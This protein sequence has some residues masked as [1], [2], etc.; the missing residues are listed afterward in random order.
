MSEIAYNTFMKRDTFLLSSLS[1]HAYGIIAD[2]TF[3]AEILEHLQQ[4]HGITT[5][6]NPDLHHRHFDS[7]TIDDAREIKSMHSMR[8]VGALGKKIFVLSIHGIGHEAQNAL[9][10]LLEEPAEY[11]HFFLVIPSEHILLPTVKSRLR[12]IHMEETGGGKAMSAQKSEVS[13]LAATFLKQSPAKRL[14][15]V[16]KIVEDISKEKKTKQFAIEFLEE[17][18]KGIYTKGGAAQSAG[19]LQSTIVAQRYM[20]DRSPSVKMLL[21]YVALTV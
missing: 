2:L 18:Q 20:Y 11:A 1:H 9:L 19:P 3:V 17:V 7:F 8:P 15:T 21:E 16:K 5:L 4:A 10:K 12:I 14:E 13:E 6:G